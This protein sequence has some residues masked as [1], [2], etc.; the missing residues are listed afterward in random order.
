MVRSLQLSPDIAL[1]ASATQSVSLSFSASQTH[2]HATRTYDHPHLQPF[3]IRYLPPFH[4]LPN[5]LVARAAATRGRSPI[6]FVSK[7]LP[8]FRSFAAIFFL[9][10]LL[11]TLWLF[12][13]TYPSCFQANPNSLCKTPG[14]GGGRCE[15]ARN[16]PPCSL[17]TSFSRD[18]ASG[19]SGSSRDTDHETRIT[20][21]MTAQ[22]Q[23]L[24]VSWRD[25]RST[26]TLDSV[27]NS[28]ASRP[29]P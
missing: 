19:G 9:F 3:V 1:R 13:K 20:A 22:Y 14:V 26:T 29:W 28:T 2:R 4:I 12:A 7:Y 17:P 11:R 21:L 5:S 23:N 8:T 15:P 16:L 18:A 27:K 10:T 6:H 25:Q 24:R